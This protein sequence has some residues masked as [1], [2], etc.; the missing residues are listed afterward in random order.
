MFNL[1]TE[2]KVTRLS[3]AVAAGQT[4]VNGSSVDMQGFEAVTFYVL[5]GSITSSGTVDVK[6][7]QSN[8]D[9][10]SDAFA[11]LEGTKISYADDDDNQVAVLEVVNPQERYVRPVVVRGTA[12]SVI[13]G[14]IAVQTGAKVAPVTH[15]ATTVVGSEVHHAPDEGTA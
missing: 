11:D 13:D 8:D 1:S 15:D 10:N 14:I 12:D 9:G 4:T 7:Q 3:N 2:G 5:I 6:A